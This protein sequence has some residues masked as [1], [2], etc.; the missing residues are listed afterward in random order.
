MSSQ[1]SRAPG[2][3]IMVNGS[4]EGGSSRRGRSRWCSQTAEPSSQ[5]PPMSSS[6]TAPPTPRIPAALSSLR[7]Y[8]P[9]AAAAPPPP[10]SRRRSPGRGGGWRRECD[11]NPS[12]CPTPTNTPHRSLIPGMPQK[13]PKSREKRQ[14]RPQTQ[15][16]RLKR[17]QRRT[18]SQSLKE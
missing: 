13:I 5:P 8:S 16:P 18:T 1:I 11:I 3:I 7:L 12:C 9:P 10:T 15:R 2:L 6:Q 14:R 4:T 17:R